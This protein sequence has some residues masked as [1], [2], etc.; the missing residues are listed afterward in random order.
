MKLFSK[1]DLGINIVFC[2]SISLI[3]YYTSSSTLYNLSREDNVLFSI[4]AAI[5]LATLLEIFLHKYAY[6]PF[7]A[8]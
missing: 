5:I 7:L 3:G 2:I 6:S 4:Q 1:S 8:Y